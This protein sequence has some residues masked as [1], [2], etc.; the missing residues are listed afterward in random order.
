MRALW[1]DMDITDDM[2]HERAAEMLEEPTY[3]RLLPDE[4]AQLQR[5]SEQ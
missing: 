4:A 3:K 2:L 1:P 5:V